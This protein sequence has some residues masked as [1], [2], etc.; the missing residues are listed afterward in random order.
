MDKIE[1]DAQVHFCPPRC[2][3]EAIE[4]RLTNLENRVT[5]IENEITNIYNKIHIIESFIYLSDVVEYWS[6]T[7]ALSG[8]G[9]AVI[10]AGFTYNFWGIGALNHQQ[11]LNN[12]ST[13]YLI[14]SSQCPELGYYQGDSTI[15]TLWIE[16]PAGGNLYSLPIR[17]D[18]TG[19]Y[20]TPTNQMTSLPVGT[21]FKFTQALI[22]VTPDSP[23]P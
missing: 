3:C 21:T 15:G 1:N 2:D 8:L 20:F 23:A 18:S 14:T 13:Y 17:F 10:S 9:A 7:A 5:N 12:G 16:T 11:T 19:I 4:E 22:L 6:L